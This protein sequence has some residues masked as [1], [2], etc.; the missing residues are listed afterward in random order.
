M[1]CSPLKRK[2]NFSEYQKCIR[3]I[4][5]D[6]FLGDTGQKSVF[7]FDSLQLSDCFIRLIF[8]VW[9]CK[10][11][12][13]GLSRHLPAPFLLSLSLP[14]ALRAISPL[15][16]RSSSCCLQSHHFRFSVVLI[17]F[18]KGAGVQVFCLAALRNQLLYIYFMSPLIY[19]T[20]TPPFSFPFF[21]LGVC[22]KVFD[23]YIISH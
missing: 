4:L 2:E 7:R 12:Q 15:C 18:P 23:V 14:L 17:F 11:K 9:K 21:W 20:P 19:L 13:P 8:V 10:E 5:V 16:S 6:L 22:F 1:I 3:L